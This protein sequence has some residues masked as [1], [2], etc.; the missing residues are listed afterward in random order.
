MIRCSSRSVAVSSRGRC[1]RNTGP[2]RV[3]AGAVYCP[4][5]PCLCAA[6]PR[7]RD[8]LHARTAVGNHDLS[9][10]PFAYQHGA[11]LAPHPGLRI[12]QGPCPITTLTGLDVRP[13]EVKLSEDA[14]RCGPEATGAGTR[15]PAEFTVTGRSRPL[16]TKTRT[17]TRVTPAMLHATAGQSQPGSGASNGR[18]NAR[19]T[20][21]MKR[22][23]SRF[24]V[25]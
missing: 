17:K 4:C 23:P 19:T 25:G 6:S 7:A 16:H 24:A 3:P 15:L 12:E 9:E 2:A 5:T 13:R 18:Q 1:T 20:V 21:Q 10:P 14:A 8:H 22:L 11:D